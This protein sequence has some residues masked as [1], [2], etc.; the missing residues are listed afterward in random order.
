MA[1]TGARRALARLIL[2]LPPP[3]LQLLSGGEALR[4]AGREL[5]PQLQFVL[6]QARRRPD[7]SELSLEEARAASRAGFH[8]AGGPRAPGVRTADLEVPSADRRV[9][10]RLYRPEAQKPDHPV[11]VYLH[12][13]GGVVGDLDT[14]DAFCSI[15][16]ADAQCPVL[17]ADYRLAPEHPFPAGLEDALAVYRWACANAADLGAAPGPAAVGG[18]SIGGNFAAVIAQEMVRSGEPSPAAQLL[19]YPAV[20]LRSDTQSMT[21]FAEVFPLRRRTMEWFL[22]CYAGSGSDLTEPRLSPLRQ[23]RLDGLAP[24]VVITAGFD[25]L[26]DQGEIYAHRLFEAGVPCLHRRYD[27]LAHAFVGFTGLVTAADTA[28]REIAGLLREAFEGRLPR[29]DAPEVP[30]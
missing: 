4:I 10:C 20:D 23:E 6:H 14:C 2:S 27:G 18:D 26:C 1:L 16:A 22:G 25:A 5:D 30:L 29:R 13:G 21:D 7:L 19:V 17:S 12:M 15:L 11:L 9:P 3:V 28:C 24:A 8:A